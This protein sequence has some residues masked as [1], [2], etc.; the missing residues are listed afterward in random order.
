MAGSRERDARE[1]LSLLPGA[2]MCLSP[3]RSAS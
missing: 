2:I 1:D 3:G